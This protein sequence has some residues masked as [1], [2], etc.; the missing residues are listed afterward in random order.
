MAVE[1]EEEE[2]SL[3]KQARAEK[4]RAGYNKYEKERTLRHSARLTKITSKIEVGR[5]QREMEVLKS[6]AAEKVQRLRTAG[7][8]KW[9]PEG[10][11]VWYRL[12]LTYTIIT[13]TNLHFQGTPMD[14]DTKADQLSV[15]MQG[16]AMEVVEG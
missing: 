10:D 12:K 7:N 4:K 16:M 14:I 6:R 8:R 9:A 11:K 1:G 3:E 5:G 2:R 15:A 13:S